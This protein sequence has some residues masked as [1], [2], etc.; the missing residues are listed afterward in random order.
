MGS[1]AR[2]W[3]VIVGYIIPHIA[4]GIYN[5]LWAVISFI[6]IIAAIGF[7]LLSMIFI[8]WVLMEYTRYK[9]YQEWEGKQLIETLKNSK[10]KTERNPHSNRRRYD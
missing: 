4:F 9:K 5:P 6:G 1:T 3:F 10:Y 7:I 8:D 2:S